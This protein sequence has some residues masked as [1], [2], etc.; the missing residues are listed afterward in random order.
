MVKE[1]TLTQKQEAKSS[2]FWTSLEKTD[3]S[4]SARIFNLDVGVL[5]FLVLPFAIVHCH[6][7][8]TMLDVFVVSTILLNMEF[9]L[10]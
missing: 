10:A 7:P 5:E 6:V 4:I 2:S 1:S 8:T 9:N 3:K